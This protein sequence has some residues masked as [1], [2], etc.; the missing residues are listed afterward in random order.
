MMLNQLST[1]SLVRLVHDIVV[2]FIHDSAEDHSMNIHNEVALVCRDCKKTFRVDV[3][4]F[5]EEADAFCPHCDIEFELP[6]GPSK[7]MYEESRAQVRKAI[8]E[9]TNVPTGQYARYDWEF[10]DERV[11]ESNRDIMWQ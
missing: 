1:R 5:D 7:Q 6:I 2:R 11:S 9:G 3:L 8:E 10:M 4:D